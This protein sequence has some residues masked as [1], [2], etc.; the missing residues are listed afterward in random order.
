MS[1]LLTEIKKKY[2]ELGELIQVLSKEKEI[3][4]CSIN[5]IPVFFNILQSKYGLSMADIVSMDRCE[6]IIECRQVYVY[7]RSKIDK[8]P[9]K[10]LGMEISRDR[11]TITTT[12]QTVERYI[13]TNDEKFMR[14]YNDFKHLLQ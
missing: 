3:A 13:E 11:S 14:V 12:L 10:L 4:D 2:D 6:P 7:L 8:R 9:N 1:I 5:W